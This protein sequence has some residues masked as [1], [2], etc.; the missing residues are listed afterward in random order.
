MPDNLFTEAGGLA[1]TP[2]FDFAK[3]LAFL[4]GFPITAGE[5]TL[6]DLSLTKAFCFDG[7]PY[8]F[9]IRS[10]GSAE[11]PRLEYTLYAARPIP[12]EARATLIDRL[13]FYL[14]LD[15]D[16]RPLY[17]LA[18]D[19]PSFAPLALALYGFHQVKFPTP[20][21]NACWAVISQ[22]VPLAEARKM[23]IA[24]M[25]HYGCRLTWNESEYTGFPEPA[26]LLSA[27]ESD[28]FPIL[29]KNQRKVE[30]LKAVAQ[31]FAGVDEAFLRAGDYEEVKAWL[32]NIRG[33][34][35]WSAAFILIRGLGRMEGLGT[36]EP[37]LL[38][39][40]KRRYGSGLDEEA[41]GRIA[42]RYGA[43]KGYWAYYLRAAAEMGS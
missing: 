16:L 11:E 18:R 8:L 2:P 30:Y 22:R 4:R 42:A 10:T 13:S 29:G 7:Q 21:E 23:R 36:N 35:P 38:E 15:D 14:S 1:P 24:L 19:D 40:A 25:E 37:N 33:I 28:I 39:A 5:Q 31:A 27:N 3:S 20:F 9:Y 17:A 32:L 34:G 12:P 43:H 41:L 6:A 26:P